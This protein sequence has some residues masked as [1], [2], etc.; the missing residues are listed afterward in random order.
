MPRYALPPADVDAEVLAAMRVT[1]SE[2]AN[3]W[4]PH[5]GIPSGPTTNGQTGVSTPCAEIDSSD[6]RAET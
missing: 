6:M 5:R 3:G 1:S 2:D 4:S